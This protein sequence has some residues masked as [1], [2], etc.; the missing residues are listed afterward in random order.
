[1]TVHVFGIRH[2][3]PGSARSLATALAE[4]QPDAVLV[5]GPPEADEVLP[6][7]V[8]PQMQP[9][10]ALLGYALDAPERAVFYPFASFSPEWQA[11][12]FAVSSGITLRMCDL[13]L[14]HVLAP[15][16]TGR[17]GR[18]VDPLGELAAA[19]GYDD[20]ER[21][22]EDVIEHRDEGAFAAISEAMAAVRSTEPEAVGHEAQ[23]EAA[24]RRAIRRAVA[25]GAERV[26]VVCGAWHA[27]AL[28]GGGSEAADAR[29][30]RG[31]PK[32]KVAVTWVPWTHQRLAQASG[33]GAGVASP[34]WYDH[35]F[36]HAGPDVVPRWFAEAARILREEGR[37]VS[38]GHVIEAARLAEGLAVLRGRP[39]AGIAE[40]TDA[41]RAALGDGTDAPMLLL[42]ERLVVG[43]RLGQVPDAT[44]MVPL[45][46]DVAAAQKRLRMKP[47]AA[48]RRLELD[49]R[50][51]RDRARSWLLHRL[52]MIEVPWGAL[53]D[54]RGSSGTFR[55]TWRLRWDPELA[56]RLVEAGAYGTTV[57]AAA[58]AVVRHRA[59]Q[60][61]V[62]VELARLVDACL[63]A[64]L[65]A[66]L[67]DVLTALASRAAVDADV[68]HLMDALVPLVRAARYGDVRSTD[69]SS[70]VAVVDGLLRRVSP[71]LGVAVSMLDDEGAA[72]FAERLTAVQAALVVVEGE[73][74]ARQWSEAVA[75][76]ADRSDV[77]GLV[78]GRA[79]RLL[80]DGGTWS[81]AELGRRLSQALSYG[82][83]AG[84]GASF[85]EG[86]LAG[87]GTLLLHDRE[88]LDTVDGWIA[89]LDGSAFADVVPLLRR[90][91]GSFEPAERRL[92][93]EMVRREQ[94]ANVT[95]VYGELDPDR[96]QAVL[97]TLRQLLGDR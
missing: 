59:E 71:G 47:E 50:S 77:H 67:A 14:V 33:Y 90:T 29:L 18:P 8:D 43:E 93:G 12:T 97:G 7:A 22:W 9:P 72:A 84:D 25:D 46:R 85:V 51:E 16:G 81:A 96:V 89:S 34:G 31:L 69:R 2:H 11:V 94:A 61:T 32:T 19:A 68:V 57:E 20:A 21:W 38:P 70:L 42:H 44:P 92:L 15:G 82:T 55:E 39:L 53:V 28:Q 17:R 35:L 10:V 5:E 66:A 26:A 75:G 13:P 65:P 64:E 95:A 40:V 45:A 74:D 48:E 37:L 87:S 60:A 52:A 24:M 56:V 79:A 91:F 86:V 62:L 63:L 4:L 76:L 80:H 3:G 36:R 23:R 49:L 54:G 58:V 27:P 78:R 6:L 41:A 1:V 73:A 88:L 83:P 30:L